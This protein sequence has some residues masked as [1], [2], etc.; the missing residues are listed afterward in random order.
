MLLLMLSSED[1]AVMIWLIFHVSFT[2]DFGFIVC[3]LVQ[4]F[5]AQVRQVVSGLWM[6]WH[7]SEKPPATYT[8]T[9]VFFR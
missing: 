5:T 8:L 3:N 2:H 9:C 6:Q 1:F 4:L 7:G